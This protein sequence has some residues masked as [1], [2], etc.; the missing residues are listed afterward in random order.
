MPLAPGMVVVAAALVVGDA[1]EVVDVD[2][3]VVV[4]VDV[5]LVLLV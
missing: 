5:P 2:T 4:E 3:E 1:D